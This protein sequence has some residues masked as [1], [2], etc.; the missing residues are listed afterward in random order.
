MLLIFVSNF[1][2]VVA[3]VLG[4]MK[5]GVNEEYNYLTAN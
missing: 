4:K 3:V 5:E 1:V 2:V